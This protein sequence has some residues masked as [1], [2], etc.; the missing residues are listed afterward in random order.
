M[1]K[2]NLDT[3]LTVFYTAWAIL[4]LCGIITAKI[5]HNRIIVVVWMIISLFI[6]QIFAECYI[7]RHPDP[8]AQYIRNNSG[9]IVP[10]EVY[11]E[12]LYD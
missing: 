1:E 6:S 4:L 3:Y 7:K 9:I 11:Q 5:L 2:I 8:T 12:N 10:I